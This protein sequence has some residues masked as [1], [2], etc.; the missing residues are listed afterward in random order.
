MNQ[1]HR[2]NLEKLMKNASE[3]LK[4]RPDP[5]LFFSPPPIAPSLLFIRRSERVLK[6]KDQG[7]FPSQAHQIQIQRRRSPKT[8]STSST[9]TKKANKKTIHRCAKL[10][11]LIDHIEVFQQ[12]SQNFKLLTPSHARGL[13]ILKKP[14]HIRSKVLIL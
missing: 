14:S 11:S 5:P 4:V 12:E 6:I 10:H 3:I 9:P 8:S 2:P 7:L 13:K 1:K